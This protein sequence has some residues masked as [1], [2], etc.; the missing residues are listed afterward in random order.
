ML[1]E[2][3]ATGGALLSLDAADS[4]GTSL[5]DRLSEEDGLAAWHGRPGRRSAPSAASTST[6]ALGQLDDRDRALCA[7]VAHWSVDELAARGFGS[8][9]GLYR[10]LPRLRLVLAAYGLQAA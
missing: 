3:R 9:A 2:R 1:R 5:G 6:A 4:D 8:R 7:A 10:R